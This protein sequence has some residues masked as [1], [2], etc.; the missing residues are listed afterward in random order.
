V[1][2]LPSTNL[3]GRLRTTSRLERDV[4]VLSPTRPDPEVGSGSFTPEGAEGPEAESGKKK[5]FRRPDGS[6]YSAQVQSIL[7]RWKT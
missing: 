1:L 4:I 3:D 2:D 6:L 7:G 5:P